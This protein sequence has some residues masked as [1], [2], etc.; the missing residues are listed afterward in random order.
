MLIVCENGKPETAHLVRSQKELR[1]RFGSR[2]GPPLEVYRV[3]KPEDIEV[4]AVEVMATVL[5]SIEPALNAQEP[6]RRYRRGAIGR[7]AR[8]LLSRG[9]RSEKVLGAI[10]RSTATMKDIRIYQRQ[11]A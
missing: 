8:E 9:R 10:R 3:S 5:K 11:I 7:R 1:A 4:I 2:E 6:K